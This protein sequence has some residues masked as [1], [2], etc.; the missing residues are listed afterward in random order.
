[1]IIFQ[2][3]NR[4]RRRNR[5]ARARLDHGA[6]IKSGDS[7]PVYLKFPAGT[8]IKKLDNKQQGYILSSYFADTKW[9]RTYDKEMF[10]VGVIMHFHLRFIRMGRCSD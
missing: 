2:E 6:A 9:R 10:I 7:A 8:S 3:N 5:Q 4:L 1:M